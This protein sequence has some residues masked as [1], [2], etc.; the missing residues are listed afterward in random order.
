[1]ESREVAFD[2]FVSHSTFGG[3]Y[4]VV[5]NLANSLAIVRPNWEIT[6]LGLKKTNRGT[7]FSKVPSIS[8]AK[9]LLT[10]S[11]GYTLWP[12]LD[13]PFFQGRR[14]ESIIICPN[15]VFPLYLASHSIV[16]IHDL[17]H[18]K[19]LS[20]SSSGSLYDIA[21][22][23]II[24]LYISLALQ[25]AAAVVVPSNYIRR[26]IEKTYSRRNASIFV[27]PGATSLMHNDS[28]VLQT[29]IKSNK[30]EPTTIAPFVLTIGASKRKN[31]KT[32]ILAID[33]L[34]SIGFDIQLKI[35]GGTK[36]SNHIAGVEFLGYVSDVELIELYSKAVLVCLAGEDEGFGLPVLEAMSMGTPV[37]AVAAGSLPEVVSSAGVLVSPESGVEGWVETLSW[38]LRDPDKRYDLCQ[39][40]RERASQFSWSSSAEKLASVIENVQE[41]A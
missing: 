39:L 23:K 25:Y 20:N 15:Y 40:G 4:R 21:Y 8:N 30:D 13:L 17:G 37:V 3:I 14:S 1:M 38:L 41:N 12:Q 16:Y 5:E 18:L 34:R 26:E 33:K 9:K 2:F 35:V 29:R 24:E 36:G 32:L 31:I 19:T 7:F 11:Y 22:A 28:K 6:R 10:N 27:V